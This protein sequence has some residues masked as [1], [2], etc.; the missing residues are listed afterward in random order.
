M[1]GWDF[2]SSWLL[3]QWKGNALDLQSLLVLHKYISTSKMI[4]NIHGTNMKNF[5][6]SNSHKLL[7]NFAVFY[8]VAK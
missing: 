7:F 8:Y 4:R 6:K 5:Q 3:Y 2:D 1:D